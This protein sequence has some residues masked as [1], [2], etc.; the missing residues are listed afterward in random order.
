MEPRYIDIRAH[1]TPEP[2]A[3]PYY[4]TRHIDTC[5][6]D[7]YKDSQKDSFRDALVNGREWETYTAKQL[8]EYGIDDIHQPEFEASN[9]NAP[10]IIVNG[11][12]Y[13]EV[14]SKKIRFTSPEDFPFYDYI[15]GRVRGIDEKYHQLIEQKRG[16]YM[17]VLNV[18]R[19][20]GAI[21]GAR[22]KPEYFFKDGDEWQGLRKHLLPLNKLVQ[23]M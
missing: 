22:F 15:V 4:V 3:L 20:T 23:Y 21:V 8:Y 12:H 7:I 14:K 17:F 13:I 1:R 2:E 19:V 11:R 16:G 10:D 9:Q 5:M 6:K 18:S